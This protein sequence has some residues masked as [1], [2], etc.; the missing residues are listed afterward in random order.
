[1]NRLAGGSTDLEVLGTERLNEVGAMARSVEVF[2][3]NAIARRQG[4]RLLRQTNILFNAA[5]NSM[6]QGMIVW[7]PDHCVQLVKWAILRDL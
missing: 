4:E 1:M 7:S 2:R 6:L 5:L 3:G